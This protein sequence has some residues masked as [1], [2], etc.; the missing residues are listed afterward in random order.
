MDDKW[1]KIVVDELE[2]EK[3]RR[4]AKVQ[5]DLELEK[6][7][8]F[9]QVQEEIESTKRSIFESYFK[10]GNPSTSERKMKLELR[11]GIAG[12]MFTGEEIRGEGDVPIEVALVDVE[13]GAVVDDEPE[14]SAQVEFLLLNASGGDVEGK[15]PILAGNV[16]LNLHRGLAVVNNIKI[17]HHASI[18]KPPQ[19]K[20]CA[21]L[22]GAASLRVK[23]AKT[24]AFALKIFRAKFSVWKG[25][26]IHKR[27]QD[28]KIYTVEDFLIQLLINPQRLMAIVKQPNKWKGIVNNAEA[29]L[30]SERMYCYVDPRHN[31]GVVFNILGHVLG[32][33]SGSYYSETS[34]L[35]EKEKADAEKLL[36]SAYQ[37]WGKVKAFDDQNSLQQ[38]IDY[39]GASKTVGESSSTMR[40]D[41]SFHG[42]NS[43]SMN[44]FGDQTEAVPFT[45][46]SDGS[47]FEDVDE[48]IYNTF[49]HG[50]QH[51]D[52]LM[53]EPN[54]DE[55]SDA[56]SQAVVGGRKRWKILFCVLTFRKRV[57]LDVSPNPKKQRVG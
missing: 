47:L 16:S 27:L 14:A 52:G 39:I 30:S 31:T 8:R 45:T 55:G 56:A 6:R 48:Y 49:C 12:K 46:G 22:V 43:T 11:N 42:A 53:N 32:R 23:E 41:I 36:A 17:R 18:I 9:A 50:R 2:A 29:C 51:N 1:M 33:C 40:L 35:S 19:F 24:E 57:A 20:L 10:D 7:R 13:T 4:F 34:M 44:L 28:N 25:G 5:E 21:R 26:K 38:Y 37:N 15:Q 3:R 54:A